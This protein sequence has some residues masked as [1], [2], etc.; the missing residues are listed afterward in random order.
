MAVRS[1]MLDNERCDWR[2]ILGA[3]DQCT[4]Q[5]MAALPEVLCL[6][7]TTELDFNGRA[8]AGLGPLSFEPRNRS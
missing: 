6:T 7:D 4:M 3:H 8:I 2:E 1:R 5:R